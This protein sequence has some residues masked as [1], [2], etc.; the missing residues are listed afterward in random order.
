MGYPRKK[1]NRG[2]GRGTYF[3]EN[4]PG[5]FQFFTLPQ[6]IPDKTKLNP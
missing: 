5:L 4:P 6:E 2:R 3:F 1:P